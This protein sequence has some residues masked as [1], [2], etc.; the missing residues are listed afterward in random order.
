MLTTDLLQ[1]Q[2]EQGQV[3]ECLYQICVL[4]APTISLTSMQ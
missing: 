4:G 2:G 1:E 3:E